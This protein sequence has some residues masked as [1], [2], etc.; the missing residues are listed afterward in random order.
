MAKDIT[1]TFIQR[2]HEVDEPDKTAVYT[3]GE[4]AEGARFN[5]EESNVFFIGPRGSGK[6]TLA[7]EVA[8]RLGAVFWD[9]DD[10]IVRAVGESIAEHVHKHGWPDF[11]KREH[12][13]LQ[14]ICRHRGQ[15]VATGGGIVLLP[16]NRRLLKEN[17]R[18]FYLMVD[19]E[20]LLNRLQADDAGAQRPAL[21]EEAGSL[22]EEVSLVIRDREPYYFETL[23]YILQA[24]KTVDELTEDVMLMLDMPTG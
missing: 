9:I 13:Q 8:E 23:H 4:A 15:V 7:R 18:V 2:K 6:S 19:V 24:H 14:W 12:E 16:E 10:M 5:L 22:R 1:K 17:G 20:T 11:R 21:H 3:S